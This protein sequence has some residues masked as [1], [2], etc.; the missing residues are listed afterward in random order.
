MT[1]CPEEGVCEKFVKF[2]KSAIKNNSE[3]GLR[4]IMVIKTSR[5][6]QEEAV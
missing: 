1:I 4:C 5:N 2:T 3:L 6:R